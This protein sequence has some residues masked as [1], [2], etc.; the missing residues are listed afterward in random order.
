MMSGTLEDKITQDCTMVDNRKDLISNNEVR[1]QVQRE[2]T[3]T[4]TI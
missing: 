3:M 2:W 1:Q 4:D